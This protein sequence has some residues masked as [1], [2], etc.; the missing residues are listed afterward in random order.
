MCKLYIL[1]QTAHASIAYMLQSMPVAKAA[2]QVGAVSPLQIWMHPLGICKI[3]NT[4][5]LV[6]QIKNVWHPTASA[7]RCGW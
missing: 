5:M 4:N 7:R 2:I 3:S 6:S 1:N